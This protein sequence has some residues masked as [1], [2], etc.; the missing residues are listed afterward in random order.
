M[1]NFTLTLPR[2]IF[3]LT[4]L[5]GLISNM[6]VALDRVHATYFPFHYSNNLKRCPA[7]YLILITWLFVPLIAALPFFLQT[8]PNA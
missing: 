1:Y 8:G 6:C 4:M 5:M 7:Q 2:Y 3:H